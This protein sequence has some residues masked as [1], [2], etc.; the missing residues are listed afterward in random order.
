M[1]KP[2]GTKLGA[3]HSCWEQRARPDFRKHCDEYIYFEQSF[4]TTLF[5][6]G[7]DYSIVSV[8]LIPL[9]G[10][11]PS[12]LGFKYEIKIASGQLVEIDKVITGC[13]IE[14]EGYVFD[15]DLTIRIELILG[16]T[17]CK[18]LLIVLA[19]YELEEL[20]GQL[21]ELQDKVT[22]KN[23]YSLPRI[24]GSTLTDYKGCSFLKDR[25]LGLDT[26]SYVCMRMNSK[27][28]LELVLD[29]LQL[30]TRDE[31]CRTLRTLLRLFTIVTQKCKAFDWG[32]EQELA[33]QTL[34]DKLCNALVLALL[35]GPEDFV[36]YCDASGL[37]LGCV[38]MQ[39]VK[40]E[41][42]MR[43][44]RWIEM[45]NDYDYE[46]RYHPGK[47]NVVADALSR[48]ERTNV[49]EYL[50]EIYSKRVKENK[51]ENDMFFE[52]KKDEREWKGKSMGEDEVPLVDGV[53][54]GALGALGDDS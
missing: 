38:L 43:Q 12:E 50:G 19:P 33:F 39:R 30:Q 51:D 1:E 53:L 2:K 21:K 41:L 18:G 6:S 44:R 7:V 9:L 11:E 35:D 37:G 5:D 52:T 28:G 47:A 25:T 10:L 49:I 48:K 23:R 32:E 24:D 17:D 34:K 22:A 4:S 16:C 31:A 40:Q 3:G 42:N 46:I 26:I 54:K 15:I 14:I 13:K 45:F 8:Y 36:V 27:T 29:I 20:S